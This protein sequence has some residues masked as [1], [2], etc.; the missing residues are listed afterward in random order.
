MKVSDVQYFLVYCDMI[1]VKGVFIFIV[2]SV[3]NNWIWVQVF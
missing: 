2:M 3:Y 1:I